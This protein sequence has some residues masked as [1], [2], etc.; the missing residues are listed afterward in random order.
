[1]IDLKV[2]G[3][4][5]LNTSIYLLLLILREVIM[6]PNLSFSIVPTNPFPIM[7]DLAKCFANP[8]LYADLLKTFASHAM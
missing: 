6:W 3:Y 7:I 1:M 2:V 4:Y 5:Y 8:T